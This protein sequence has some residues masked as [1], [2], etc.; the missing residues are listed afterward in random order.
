VSRCPRSS[1]P[2][3]SENPPPR[4]NRTAILLGVVR[5]TELLQPRIEPSL[6]EQF[7]HPLIKHMPGTAH[8]SQS[9]T[10]AAAPSA[11]VPSPFPAPQSLKRVDHRVLSHTSSQRRICQQDARACWRGSTHPLATTFRTPECVAKIA[12]TRTTTT[13]NRGAQSRLD[14]HRY[15]NAYFAELGLFRVTS[16]FA[17]E[18]QSCHKQQSIREPDAGEPPIRFG[19]RENVTQCVLLIP[20][21]YPLPT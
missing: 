9:K 16:A 13:D 14:H 5:P 19:G 18:C 3:A 17:R 6:R 15:S 11:N 2:S 10:L 8:R 7:I 21:G 4:R 1:R 20:I 12:P